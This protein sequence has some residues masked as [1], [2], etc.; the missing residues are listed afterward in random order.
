M[1]GPGP[2][3]TLPSDTMFRFRIK[4]LL[5][6]REPLRPE[7]RRVLRLYVQHVCQW[8]RAFWEQLHWVDISR[9]EIAN[10]DLYWAR[11]S[12]QKVV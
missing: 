6:I 8:R 2:G 7:I 10:Q 1:K 4:E 9:D 3:A 5:F 12:L 11:G